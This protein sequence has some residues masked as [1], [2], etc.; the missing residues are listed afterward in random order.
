[1][2]VF[3]Q[4][5]VKVEALVP[6]RHLELQAVRVDER[7]LWLEGELALPKAD[8]ASVSRVLG[9]GTTVRMKTRTAQG[10]SCPFT[11]PA[12]ATALL[13]ALGRDPDR[14]TL[15]VALEPSLL[16]AGFDTLPWWRAFV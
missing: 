10:W 11:N 7:G 16:R 14:T 8:I 12:D 13:V 1:M 9:E 2:S 15:E 5:G 3:E 6:V 4:Q